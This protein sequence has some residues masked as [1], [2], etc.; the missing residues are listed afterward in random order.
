[1]CSMKTMIKIMLGIVLLLAIGYVVFPQ[2]QA[3]IAILAPYLLILACP[4]MMYFMRKEKNT[5]SQEKE[6]MPDQEDK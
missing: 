6:Q 3:S 5:P 2:W 4:L 1:M